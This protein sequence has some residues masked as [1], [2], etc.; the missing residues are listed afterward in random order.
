MKN[1]KNQTI[2]DSYRLPAKLFFGLFLICLC[3]LLSRYI[4]IS[5]SVFE[6]KFLAFRNA[7]WPLWMEHFAAALGLPAGVLAFMYWGMTRPPTR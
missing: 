6:G 2:Y 3:A 7:E 1:M 5:P 4:R